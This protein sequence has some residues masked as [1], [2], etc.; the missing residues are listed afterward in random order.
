MATAFQCRGTWQSI[1]GA[2]QTVPLWP[3]VPV[4]S[5]SLSARVCSWGSLLPG[6]DRPAYFVG[7]SPAPK[8]SH[9]H[10]LSLKNRSDNNDHSLLVVVV[11]VVVVGQLVSLI[12]L[13]R[14]SLSVRV[15]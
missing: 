10:T 5:P 6:A 9:M 15:R 12:P 14:M 8:H 2:C 11:V 13:V 7:P 1:D 3:R 4:A